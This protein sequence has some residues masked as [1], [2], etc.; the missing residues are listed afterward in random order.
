[1]PMLITLNLKM[2]YKF[3]NWDVHYPLFNIHSKAFT[4]TQLHS[5][6]GQNSLKGAHIHPIALM[7]WSHSHNGMQIHLL[8]SGGC[9]HSL[10]GDHVHS[11][12]SGAVRRCSHSLNGIHDT[13]CNLFALT[14]CA[15]SNCSLKECANSLNFL[16]QLPCGINSTVF[17]HNFHVAQTILSAWNNIV[18]VLNLLSYF[19]E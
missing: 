4:P 11:V 7:G 16:Q 14:L 10:K 8:R 13:L 3:V 5:G 19:I 15:K 9:S 17:N 1:M 6:G 12:N 18:C 2:P